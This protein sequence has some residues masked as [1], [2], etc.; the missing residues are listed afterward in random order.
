MLK[1]EVLTNFDF[2]RLLEKTK[3]KRLILDMAVSGAKVFS[4]LGAETMKNNILRGDFAPLKES[5]LKTR[6]AR[7]I[8]GVSPLLEG[9]IQAS[10][11]PLMA[12]RW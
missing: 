3:S 12:L 5:T 1:T 9:Y 8:G 4:H 10:K 2:N 7:G 6:R 11:T